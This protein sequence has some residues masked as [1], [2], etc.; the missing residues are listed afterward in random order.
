MSRTFK[1]PIMPWHCALGRVGPGVPARGGSGARGLSAAENYI[2]ARGCLLLS[3]D[4]CVRDRY[5]FHSG[6]FRRSRSFHACLPSLSCLS[7]PGLGTTKRVKQCSLL[8]GSTSEAAEAS[9]KFRK[10]CKTCRTR[11]RVQNLHL[12]IF[13]TSAQ[14]CT[15][16]L[17]RTSESAFI[18]CLH[19]SS[20]FSPPSE[21]IHC[22][23]NAPTC[24]TARNNPLSFS[25]PV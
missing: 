24:C 22:K 6:N 16:A 5:K 14:R 11:R 8:G 1:T 15:A 19:L 18:S 13:E 25:P 4:A 21:A 12:N 23:S 3:R 10:S 17:S 9:L 20:P 7:A 2:A